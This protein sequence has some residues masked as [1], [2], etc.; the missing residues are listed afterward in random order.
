MA[1][2]RTRKK[3]SLALA[4][5]PKWLKEIWVA[6]KRLGLEKLS[7]REINA[8]VAEVRRE[9]DPLYGQVRRITVTLSERMYRKAKAAAKAEGGSLSDYGRQAI[10]QR[11][12]KGTSKQSSP[13]A[14][15]AISAR[16]ERVKAGGQEK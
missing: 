14:A 11:L 15:K 7:M 3:R 1:V 4:D 16:T 5:A 10:G 6:S 8:I 9:K 12:E 13:R 2:P